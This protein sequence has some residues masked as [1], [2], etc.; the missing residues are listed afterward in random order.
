MINDI[1]FPEIL[2]GAELDL[3]LSKGWFRMGQ[4]IFTTDIVR[5]NDQ[6]IPVFWLRIDLQK[7]Q[8][9]RRQNR[10]LNIN[11]QATVSIEPF[12]LKDEYSNLYT[13]YSDYVTFDAPNSIEEFLF[14]GAMYNIY[15]TQVIE[16]RESGKLIAAGIFDEGDNSI[17]GIMNFYDP[18]YRERSPGKFCM[19]LKI[20]YALSKGMRWYYLGYI[21]GGGNTKFDYKLFP[22]RHASEVFYRK[23]QAWVPYVGK[24]E[25]VVAEGLGGMLW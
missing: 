24:G 3:F 11:R 21:A 12:L 22:D 2:T 8:F 25:K 10:I 17:A 15:N 4:S 13:K 23:E 6:I 1:C 16:V 9:G 5:V 19:L 18:D 20:S 14:Y 7:M